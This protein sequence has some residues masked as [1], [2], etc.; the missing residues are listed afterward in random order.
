MIPLAV[1]RLAGPRGA[2]LITAMRELTSDN[3]PFITCLASFCGHLKHRSRLGHGLNLVSGKV[4]DEVLGWALTTPRQD[5][6]WVE[7]NVPSVDAYLLGA[8]LFRYPQV[9]GAKFQRS[10]L[11]EAFA[12]GLAGEAF[13]AHRILEVARADNADLRGTRDRVRSLSSPEDRLWTADWNAALLLSIAQWLPVDVRGIDYDHIF[14][15]A[16]AG[17]MWALSEYGRR[18]HHPYRRLVNSVGNLWALDLGTNRALQ[19]TPPIVKMDRLAASVGTNSP[20]VIWPR[21]RWSLTDDDVERFIAV[22]EGLTDD[23]ESIDRAMTVFR[24]LVT[25]RAERLLDDALRQFPESRLFAADADVSPADPSTVRRDELAAALGVTAPKAPLVIRAGEPATGSSIGPDLD[26]GAVWS[27]R[28]D[29]LG[30]VWDQATRYVTKLFDPR[31]R[32]VLPKQN[33][34]YR[35]DYMRWIWLGEAYGQSHV[36]VGV[37]G[38]VARMYDVDAPLWVR[39]AGDLDGIVELRDRL[40]RSD[41]RARTFEETDSIWVGIVVDPDVGEEP[42]I[43][44]VTDQL[45]RIRSYLP[46]A[47]AGSASR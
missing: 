42:Q 20:Y 22:D 21:D 41:F 37:A 16:Q 6:E 40:L 19:D 1:D 46:V 13:P 35:F 8:T 24:D 25:V 31:R 26:L 10:A 5:V 18:M 44:Q 12:A 3:S 9:L 17:R 15:S 2:E 14:P 27:S 32:P 29:Q 23:A 34:L 11:V 33:R 43:D 47:A 36:C 28:Q 4:W 39:A 38:E 7:R 45:V 30:R